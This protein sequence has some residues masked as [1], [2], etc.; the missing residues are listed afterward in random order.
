MRL[1]MTCDCCGIVW[2]FGYK[3]DWV[4]DVYVKKPWIMKYTKQ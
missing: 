2:I 1:V 3:L 4:D